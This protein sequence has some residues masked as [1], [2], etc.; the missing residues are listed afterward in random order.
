MEDFFQILC[1]SQKVQTLPL[2]QPFYIENDLFWDF[3]E[4]FYFGKLSTYAVGYAV[5]NE[6]SQVGIYNLVFLAWVLMQCEFWQKP[7]EAFI[8]FFIDS[9]FPWNDFNVSH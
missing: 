3:F 7:I 8:G 4:T 1:S 2:A 9:L 5:L 6:I